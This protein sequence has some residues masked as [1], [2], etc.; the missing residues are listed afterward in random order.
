M[1]LLVAAPFSMAESAECFAVKLIRS[2]HGGKHVLNE[3]R[4]SQ[5]QMKTSGISEFTPTLRLRVSAIN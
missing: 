1:W 5:M 2:P 3:A 4:D